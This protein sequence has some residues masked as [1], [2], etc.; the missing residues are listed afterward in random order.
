MSNNGFPLTQQSLPNQILSVQG[1][2][3]Q[4][5]YRV[6]ENVPVVYIFG[7]LTDD[8]TFTIKHSLQRPHFYVPQDQRQHVLRAQVSASD[9]KSFDN[10]ALAKVEVAIPQDTPGVRDALHQLG[11]PTYEADV[12][13]AMRY[14]IDRG[15]KGG[16]HIEGAASR[17]TGTDLVFINPAT[18][19]ADVQIQP[20]VLSFDIETN[21]HSDQL[22]AIA[23][24]GCGLDEV[25]VV[26]PQMRAMPSHAVA[27]NICL[28]AAKV[29]LCRTDLHAASFAAKLQIKSNS[30]CNSC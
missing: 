9:F 21:P 25:V 2:I 12:R 18:T 1:T 28:S 26:D 29:S 10:Q 15:I 14:L 27:G 13:F 20:R 24:Y 16:I 22:L 30:F 7:R 19:P 17:G 11:V 3:L 6:H 5:T 23:C 4:A 8:R